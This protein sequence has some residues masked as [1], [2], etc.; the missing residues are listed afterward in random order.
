M[1]LCAAQTR[2][3]GE[4]YAG[5]PPVHLSRMARTV[6]DPL[7]TLAWTSHRYSTTVYHLQR[8]DTEALFAT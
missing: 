1:I 4:K 6:N 5:L 8:V 3:P 7:S 2:C